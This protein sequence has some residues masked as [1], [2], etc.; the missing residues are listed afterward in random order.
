MKA[1]NYYQIKV[2]SILSKTKSLIN[3]GLMKIVFV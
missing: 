2:K 3:Q 1:K